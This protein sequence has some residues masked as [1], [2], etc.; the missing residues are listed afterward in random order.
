LSVRVKQLKVVNVLMI[1]MFDCDRSLV[2]CC[3]LE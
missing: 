3:Q 2:I 1:V